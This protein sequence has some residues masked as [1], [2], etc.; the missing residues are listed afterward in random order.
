MSEGQLSWVE[1]A[2]RFLD[3]QDGDEVNK[4]PKFFPAGRR[5]IWE[6]P[7]GSGLRPHRGMTGHWKKGGPPGTLVFC[8]DCPIRTQARRGGTPELVNADIHTW[9][10]RHNR[11]AKVEMTRAKE[12]EE[13]KLDY[14]KRRTQLA[15][16][17]KIQ[18]EHGNWNYDPYMQGMFNGLELAAAIME[19]RT[20]RFRKKPDDGWLHDK[21]VELKLLAAEG[22][23]QNPDALLEAYAFEATAAG[24]NKEGK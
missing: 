12:L 17:L 23:P 21:P 4:H 9:R 14:E 18:G 3:G 1:R 20:P 11:V 5:F 6:P 16:V 8:L 13:E 7:K 2:A 22:L 24:D 15:E 19:G 10:L